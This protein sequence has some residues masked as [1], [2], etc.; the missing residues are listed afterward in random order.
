M[1]KRSF[2]FS[3]GAVLVS[4]AFV[5]CVPSVSSHDEKGTVSDTVPSDDLYYEDETTNGSGLG[6]TYNGK[7][8]VAVGGGI[9]IPFD[10]SGP[11]LGFG[12]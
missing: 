11:G 6:M 2:L 10:G 5:G 7:L 9:V 1:V 12:Y 8:G 3:V 4:V